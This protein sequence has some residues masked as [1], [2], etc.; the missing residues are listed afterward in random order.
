MSASAKHRFF[1]ATML[2]AFV[3]ALV[4]LVAGC[5][6]VTPGVTI[7]ERPTRPF[8]VTVGNGM[9]NA[10]TSDGDP[11]VLTIHN[12]AK[13]TLQVHVKCD[14]T[15]RYG[16]IDTGKIE[17]W[18]CLKPG[19]EKRRFVEFMNIDAIRRDVCRINDA[20]PLVRECIGTTEG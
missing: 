20:W 7:S 11:T 1:V 9:Y 15:T 10:W 19:Q 17:W 12:Y 18:T 13:D 4:V 3:L 16:Y 6:A 5:V 2:A 8:A 14:P